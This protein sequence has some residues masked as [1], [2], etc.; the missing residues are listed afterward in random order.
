MSTNL[1][2]LPRKMLFRSGCTAPHSNFFESALRVL[3]TSSRTEYVPQLSG[4]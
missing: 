4:M 3:D 2:L 1:S